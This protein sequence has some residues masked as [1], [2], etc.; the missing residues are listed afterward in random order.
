MRILTIAI[1]LL[2]GVGLAHAQK[3]ERSVIGSTGSQLSAGSLRMNFTVGETVIEKKENS[4]IKLI[5]GFHARAS[6]GTNAIVQVANS[7]L[8]V[9]PNPFRSSLS[10]LGEM[11]I[12]QMEL[13]SMDGRLVFQSM[14]SAGEISVP[15]LPSG[16]Y[17]LQLRNA[18]AEVFR[19]RLMRQ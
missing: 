16:P 4:S 17:V 12:K 15:E 5:Q 6:K 18:N 10:F 13:Y 19:Y 7:R 14:V 11:Q 2:L 3:L 8:K 9:V 1:A